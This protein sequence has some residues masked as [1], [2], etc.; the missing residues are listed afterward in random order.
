MACRS[1]PDQRAVR[2]E[3]CSPAP[4]RTLIGR[5]ESTPGQAEVDRRR[6][7][8]VEGDRGGNRRSALRG[9]AR[10]TRGAQGDPQDPGPPDEKGAALPMIP[11]AKGAAPA[12]LLTRGV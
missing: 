6:S 3:N 1:N 2:P 8:A 7:A 10:R 5:A 9:N 12:V 11:V 4:D